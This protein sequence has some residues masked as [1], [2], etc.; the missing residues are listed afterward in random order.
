MAYLYFIGAFFAAHDWLL[1]WRYWKPKSAPIS[2]NL[3]ATNLT[4]MRLGYYH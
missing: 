4:W 2:V 1:H 3:V